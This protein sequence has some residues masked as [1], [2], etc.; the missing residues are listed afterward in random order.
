MAWELIRRELEARGYWAP[1]GDDGTTGGGG[2]G[3]SGESNEDDAGDDTG[4]DDKSGASGAED[5]D[6]AKGDKSKPS[7]EVAKLLKESMSRKEQ[8]KGLKAQLDEANR[9][10]AE[11]GELDL[12]E[13]RNLL[14]EREEAKTRELEKKGEWDRLREQLV[15]KHE[16]IVADLQ[17]QLDAV[18][19]EL[20]VRDSA[21]EELTVGQ[22]FANS[23]FIGEEL[24]LTPSK[25]RVVYGS[26]F[27]VEN[28]RVVAYDSPRGAAERT[29]LID[30][31]GAPLEFDAAIQ[32][33]I[34]A[35]PD[36]D[37]LIR[38]KAKPGAGST[39]TPGKLPE[40][41]PDV[42]GQ[43]RIEAALRSQRKP[44]R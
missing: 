43:S 3:G 24:T 4:S 1:A 16:K 10:L 36:R 11:I 15:Q 41:R 38:S 7:D 9:R 32:A 19:Q 30:E 18:R 28:G 26:H 23:R 35:D 40:Q 13:V 8:I 22:S 34:D 39:T 6:K 31:S 5:D 27:E 20:T 42:K 44:G 14:Q 37:H 33:L 21:I 29:Q 2:G 12:D 17:A 25:A